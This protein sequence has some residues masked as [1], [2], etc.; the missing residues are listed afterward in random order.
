VSSY[1]HVADCASP[2]SAG[3][4]PPSLPAGPLAGMV[5]FRAADLQVRPVGRRGAVLAVPAGGAAVAAGTMMTFCQPVVTAPA[6][7]RGG[8]VLAGGWLPDF[9]RP[10]ELERHLGEGVIEALARKAVADG[11]MP[12]PR[13][14]RIMSLE[15]TIRL[16]IAM[17]LMPE[18]SYT[19]ALRQLAGL[20]AGVAWAAEWHVPVSRVI[21]DW[22]RKM[23]PAVMENLFWLAAGPLAGGGDDDAAAGG[24]V[25]VLGGMPVC[26]I[27]GML[28]ALADTPANR[29]MFGCTGTRNQEGPGSAPFPQLLAV[30]MTARAGRAALG[31][32]TGKARAGEQTLLARLIRRRAGLFAGRVLVFDRNFPGH[33]IITAILDAG[34]HVVAR[35]KSN[36][37]LPVT[38]DGWLPDG[39]RLTWLNAPS[40]KKA[41]ALPVRAAEHNAVLPCGD[42]QEVSETCT[43]IT[44]LLDHQAVSAEQVRGAYQSRWPASETT[45]GE[46]KTTI[47]GAGDRTSG[48]VLRSGTPRLVI[49]EFW[50]WMTAT[51]LVRASAAASL[52]ADAAVARALRRRED[53]GPVTADQVS[54][55]AA[56]HNAVRSMTQSRVTVST[57]LAALTALAED[58]S[59][60]VLHT[61]NSTGRNRHSPGAESPARLPAHRG[62]QENRHR[63]PAADPVPPRPGLAATC[64]DTRQEGGTPRPAGTAAR[65]TAR[66]PRRHAAFAMPG[67]RETRHHIR[68]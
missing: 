25:L 23:P 29:V 38:P 22:R 51:Q 20:L 6:V 24:P 10:G 16:T 39:S 41:G 55:T 4:L 63:N 43:L 7:V 53:S 34:G 54:F 49:Q 8:A 33:A 52:T 35:V 5:A 9:V 32:I 58:T 66:L 12:A 40:G 11:R 68:Q 46:D 37:A 57:S 64:P 1:L 45:F 14:R 17:T 18:A 27:D 61:L 50:A 15:L 42:G 67:H 44:T 19:G 47:T 26:G 60:A 59:R 31:A 3:L 36:L 30:I 28:V 13:R 56:R 21:T 48:P 2:D 62:H 65:G